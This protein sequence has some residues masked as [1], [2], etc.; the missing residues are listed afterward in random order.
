MHTARNQMSLSQLREL[1]RRGFLKGA[2]ATAGMVT[3][4]SLL[5][6]QHASA[7]VPGEEWW[8]GPQ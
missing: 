1:T 7:V 4:S 2:A 8:L 6:A 5:P 3:L